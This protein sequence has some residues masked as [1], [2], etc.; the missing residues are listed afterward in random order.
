[1]PENLKLATARVDDVDVHMKTGQNFDLNPLGTRSIEVVLRPVM[2]IRIKER[3][4]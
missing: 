2:V 4:R 3:T 1:M